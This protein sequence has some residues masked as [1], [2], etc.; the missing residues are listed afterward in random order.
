MSTLPSRAKRKSGPE[1]AAEIARTAREIARYDG[2][3]AITLRAIAARIG[4]TPALVSHYEPSTEGLVA[5]T[6][7]AIAGAEL[8]EITRE[9]SAL[10]SS[11]EALRALIDTLLG[12][13]RS[14]VTTVWLDAWS[15]GRRNLAL[16]REVGVQMDAWQA[17]LV[18]LLNRGCAR[19]EFAVADSGALAWQ[20]LAIIDGINAH[21]VVRYGDARGQRDLVR[22]VTEHELGLP[23]GALAPASV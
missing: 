3:D 15:V 21:A 7:G 6:F 17:F 19:G 23:A 20:L 2:L 9:L 11:V 5:T 10:P 22:T 16:A 8:A 14:T 4:V 18:A 1:R 13:D 12:P